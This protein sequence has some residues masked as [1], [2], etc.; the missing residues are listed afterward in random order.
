[1][2]PS[3]AFPSG[4]AAKD[5]KVTVDDRLTVAGQASVKGG[6]GR[7]RIGANRDTDG[8]FPTG[9]ILAL[10]ALVALVARLQ[11]FGNPVV[12]FD[13]QYYLLVG[14]RM[15]AG[16]W[17][18][19]DLFDR[20]PIGLFVLYAAIRGL[21]GE[22]TLQYQLVAAAFAI[23]TAYAIFAIGRR[24]NGERGAL[25]A[26]VA[27]L[28]WLNFC[29]GEGGQSPVFYN[30]FVAAAAVLVIDA[31]AS[32][33]AALGRGALAMLM[34][35]V[36]MQVKYTAVFE[37]VFLG[38]ALLLIEW[39]RGGRLVRLAPAAAARVGAAL[40]PT[41]LAWGVYAV[42]GAGDAFVFANF[43][44]QFGR[45]ADPGATMVEGLA[46]IAAILSPLAV[47]AIL[48]ARTPSLPRMSF[49]RLWLAVAIVAM[50]VLR[51]F[52][53][54]H[55]ALP[56]LVP[57]VLCAAP[58]FDRYPRAALTTLIVAALAGQVVLA[59]VRDAKGGRAEA[60]AVAAAARPRSGGCLYVYD[61][62][63]ALYRLTGSCLPTHFAFPGHL[64]SANEASRA[65]LGVD[66]SVEVARILAA[67]PE[68]IVIDLPL[69]ERGNRATWRLVRAELAA[70]YAV[71]A[72][73]T[74]GGSRERV[75]YRL[76]GS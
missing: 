46:V 61:G 63:P 18:Y 25:L 17:P 9:Q 44:S 36:A 60:V 19:V 52:A 24:I 29:E 65:A 3:G 43:V 50:L 14:D 67:G 12:G 64:N 6:I 11:T 34:V 2:P 38:V 42:A 45:L 58:A 41:A 27:Y 7:S 32:G 55:Y 51:S 75:V 40:A 22:G 37:G 23:A 15:W 72:V 30:L 39:R 28:L 73:V 66:P 47:F 5:P 59:T 54:P 49:V 1:M 70:R 56:V 16:A 68:T 8:R 74:T 21:G 53:S 31:A 57:L 10:F 76:R 4:N 48:A 26:G 33:R 62:Y 71:A 35:G 13:E 20:K 69:F